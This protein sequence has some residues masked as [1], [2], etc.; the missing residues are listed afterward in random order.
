[1]YYSQSYGYASMIDKDNIF[2]TIDAARAHDFTRCLEIL[3]IAEPPKRGTPYY[4]ALEWMA[5][6]VS[7]QVSETEPLSP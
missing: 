4:D 6:Y 2:R 1:M 5:D 3:G 7:Q